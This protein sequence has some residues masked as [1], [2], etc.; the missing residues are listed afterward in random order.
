M[1]KT[2]K[3]K[4]NSD[5]INILI[6][7]LI[8]PLLTIIMIYII[9]TPF[10]DHFFTEYSY[11]GRIYTLDNQ[12]NI[13]K[14]IDNINIIIKNIGQYSIKSINIIFHLIV[15]VRFISAIQQKYSFLIK[16]LILSIFITI[17]YAVIISPG[18]N[19]FIQILGFSITI[20]T[21]LIILLCVM[22]PE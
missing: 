3:I 6:N 12:S 7:L 8:V 19:I 22:I 9:N 5:L 13:F 18:L 17:L 10:F 2:V 15:L 1:G 21:S 4:I 20:I 11:T 16:E 14:S